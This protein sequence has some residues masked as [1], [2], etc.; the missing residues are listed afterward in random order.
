M[1][2]RDSTIDDIDKHTTITPSPQ[3]KRKFITDDRSICDIEDNECVD[4]NGRKKLCDGSENVTG[5]DSNTDSLDDVDDDKKGK[6]VHT[7][8][9]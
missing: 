2:V 1:S 3:S 6:C 5:D 9:S 8:I 4:T 7:L